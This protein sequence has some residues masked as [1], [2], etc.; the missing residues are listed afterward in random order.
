[1]P[2]HEYLIPWIPRV[3]TP[4]R[5]LNEKLWALLSKPDPLTDEEKAFVEECE[6]NG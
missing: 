1:V 6:R 2:P 3:D 5:Q 4:V